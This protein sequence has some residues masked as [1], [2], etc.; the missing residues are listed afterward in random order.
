MR[1]EV[2]RSYVQFLPEIRAL[3]ADLRSQRKAAME[4]R[5][6]AVQPYC[7][8]CG[9]TDMQR[10]EPASV[11][12][13]NAE[14]HFKVKVPCYGCCSS[15][16]SGRFAPSPLTVGCLPA[17]PTVSLDVSLSTA[18]QPARWLELRMLQL[19]DTLMYRGGRSIAVHS[20][21]AAIHRQHELNGCSDPL[22]FDHFKRQL[23]EGIM[24]R[25]KISSRCLPACPPTCSL[26]RTPARLPT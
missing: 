10:V 26:V 7:R 23:G 14:E 11:L 5:L 19:G 6:A 21:A 20:F 17:T 1:P 25:G 3:A 13:L 16:C 22:G 4:E 8:S 24:V 15:G 12:Y 9:G 2:Q 18:A